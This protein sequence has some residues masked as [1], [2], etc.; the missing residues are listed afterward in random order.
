MIDQLLCLSSLAAKT[1]F[2]K[3]SENMDS[4]YIF[5]LYADEGISDLYDI[6]LPLTGAHLVAGENEELFDEE[7][8]L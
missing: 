5:S 4:D 8:D 3:L 7:E 1:P 6:P 2:V